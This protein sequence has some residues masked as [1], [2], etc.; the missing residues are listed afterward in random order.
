MAD[1]KVTLDQIVSL[2]K[3]R[4]FIF[5]SSEIYGGLGACWDYGPL[6]V[7]LK[8]N[9]KN[10]WWDFMVRS[11]EDVV[12][13]DGSILM[14]PEVWVASGHVAGF[15]D[16][17]VD[18]RESKNRYRF[19]QML[20][21]RHPS[22][23]DLPLFAFMEDNPSPAEAKI[24]KMAKGAGLEEFEV[25]PLPNIAEE[26]QARV[27]G[28]DATQPDTLTKP[29][30]FNLMFKTHVGA[31][32]ETASV[33][34]LRPETAQAIF[35]NFKNV[36]QTT[37]MKVPFGIAQIGKAFRNEIV[38]G[39]ADFPRHTGAGSTLEQPAFIFQ[40]GVGQA[41]VARQAYVKSLEFV[42]L[43]R[44]RGEHAPRRIPKQP[45]MAAGAKQSILR[46]DIVVRSQAIEKF[47]LRDRGGGFP[48]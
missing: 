22:R 9:I 4:G 44:A 15:H 33:V 39:S 12:G 21:Y 18:C 26:D 42:V 7:E 28:P 40:P 45:F 35:V 31:V 36:Q 3:R 10:C 8:Q 25:I 41:Q 20:A 14:H 43:Q 46:T 47:Q 17:L 1:T 29:R 48:L 11:R 24:K 34:Y 23:H 32:E 27:I 5:Q 2:S 13:I 19:D 16:P 37:R 38:I 6:G 30:Q